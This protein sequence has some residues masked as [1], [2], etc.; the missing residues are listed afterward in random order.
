MFVLIRK[1]VKNRF[2]FIA[3][4]T[5]Y[6]ATLCAGYIFTI[7][8]IQLPYYGGAHY[9]LGGSY[10][11]LFTLGMTLAAFDIPQK[12]LQFGFG[13]L[14]APLSAYVAL[15]C[16][17]QIGWTI[18]PFGGWLLNPP[19]VILMWYA[20]SVVW[21]I[22]AFVLYLERYE[23]IAKY[24]LQPIATVGRYSLDIFLFHNVVYILVTKYMPQIITGCLRNIFLFVLPIIIPML[25][26]KT[27]TELK[28]WVLI[29]LKNGL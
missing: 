26:R 29:S 2:P 6:I 13:N 19:G 1:C 24:V 10:L 22:S 23:L 7:K 3:V 17:Q 27:Y 18:E 28:K 9:L 4:C 16:C 8:G 5:L 11:F 25:G 21:C 14:L 15:K 12:M 20:I